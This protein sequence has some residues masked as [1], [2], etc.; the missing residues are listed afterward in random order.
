MSS[1]SYYVYILTTVNNSVLYTGVT[2]DLEKRKMEHKLR[3]KPG[4]TKKYNVDRLVYFEVFDD[5]NLAIKREKKIKGFVRQ[6]KIELING[7]N[8]EW[9]DLN[10]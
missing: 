9:K 5:I 3:V 7:I 8:P 10:V 2:S 4:F 1:K 6:K